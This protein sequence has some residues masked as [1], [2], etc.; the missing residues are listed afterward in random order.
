MNDLDK[1]AAKATAV[2]PPDDD[3]T[4]KAKRLLASLAKALIPKP[5]K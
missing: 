2:T 3:D 4:A 5:S 1:Y